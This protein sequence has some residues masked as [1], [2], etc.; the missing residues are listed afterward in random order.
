METLHRELTSWWAKTDVLT[1]QIPSARV[2]GVSRYYE[3]TDDHDSDGDGLRDAEV[4]FQS[5]VEPAFR[6]NSKTG[7]KSTTTVYVCGP[8]P[9]QVEHTGDLLAAA[10][11]SHTHSS[12]HMSIRDVRLTSRDTGRDDDGIH[13]ILTFAI[14][15][16][17]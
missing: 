12:E 5:D 8:D 3:E 15:F 17:E 16:E 9:E 13:G 1:E 2:S 6:T 10:W 11:D 7:W 14:R 4:V